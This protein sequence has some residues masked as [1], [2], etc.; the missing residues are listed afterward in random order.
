MIRRRVIPDWVGIGAVS[1]VVWAWTI[2]VGV[3]VARDRLFTAA[4]VAGAALRL[5][6]MLGYPGALWFPDS[7][8]Y[9]GAALR[10]Q[11]DLSRTVGY[12]LFLRVLEPLHSLTLVTGAQHLMGLGIAIIVYALARRSEVPRGWAT[13]ATLPVLLD[14][15]EIEDEHMVMPEALFTFL[16]ALAMLLVLL[17][18]R[19]AWPAA[20]AAGLLAGYAADVRSEGLPILIL[21]PAF[22]LLRGLRKGRS[23]RSWEWRGWLAAGAMA[24]ACVTPVAAYA[25]WFHSWTGS[26]ALT[27][28]D[29]LYLWGRV[30]SFAQCPVISPPAAE[31]QVCPPGPP[32]SRPTPGDYI[33]RA[34]QVNNLA[35]GPLTAANDAL[36]RD[37]AIRA[38]EAQPL[39][40][41]HAV[42]SGLALS[43]EWPRRPYPDAQTVSYYYFHLEPQ[44][45]PAL[46]W[47]PGGAADSDTAE[48]GQAA[49]SRVDEP[50]ASLIAHYQ[51]LFYTPGPLFGLI[52]LTGLGALLRIRRASR[53]ARRHAVS[54]LP[55][56]TAI[57]LLV[58]PIAAADFS[59]RYLLPVLP[60]ACLA[61]ALAFTPA[62]MPA[63]QDPDNAEATRR[64]PQTE[65]VGRES[66]AGPSASHPVTP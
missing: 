4:L 66:G 30:S 15:F 6:A 41:L 42:L 11:P 5:L 33:W 60:F 32:S 47:I 58:I 40:Y 14:G 37:F 59:Y 20:L 29:G 51:R 65:P 9:L 13:A 39:G 53:P 24:A 43:V 56:L 61:A 10:P 52:L 28:A 18:D 26:Y 48:Y 21:F 44:A 46:T 45:V 62:R 55:W 16:I 38:I 57:T 64:R 8:A 36:L 1:A 19:V 2:R 23:W 7:F 63:T 3:W 17:R 22:M 27:R 34:P 25:A 50:F 31:L 54:K 35:G 12:S 49:P